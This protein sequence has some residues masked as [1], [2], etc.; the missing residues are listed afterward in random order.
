MSERNRVFALVFIMAVVALGS[1]GV[2]FR[3]L[4]L[5]AFEEQRARL[6]E[7]VLSQARLIEAI[8][9]FDSEYSGDYPGGPEAATLSQIIDAQRAYEALGNTGEFTVAKRE[10]DSIV[11][12]HR[13]RHGELDDI[14]PIPFD[15]SLAEPMR[16]AL[17]GQSGTVVG[18]DFRGAQVLAAQGLNIEELS[19]ERL[20]APMSGEP[21][22]SAKADLQCPPG[23]DLEALRRALEELADDLMVDIQL[24]PH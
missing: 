22:F 21:L 8:A 9:R 17:L 4:Y 23:A 24:V 11:F 16:R 7:I 5:T 15:S 1:V 10:G 12:V 6:V 14:R 19:T 3:M 2:A 20:T 13:Q 18:R